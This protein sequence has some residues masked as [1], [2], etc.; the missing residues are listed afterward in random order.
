MPRACYGVVGFVDD[1]QIG[2]PVDHWQSSGK[3]LHRRNLHRV[4]SSRYASR[5]D[6]M[7]DACAGQ[8]LAGLADELAPV[9]Q[10]QHVAA[11]INRA[12]GDR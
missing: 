3:R 6:T 7:G 8:L 10:D 12:G 5:D 2:L 9:D 1:D 4:S 11:T